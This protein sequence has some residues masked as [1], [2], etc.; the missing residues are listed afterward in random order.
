LI[1]VAFFDPKLLYGSVTDEDFHD[2]LVGL[3]ISM[4]DCPA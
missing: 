3:R 2:R 1:Y 4:T